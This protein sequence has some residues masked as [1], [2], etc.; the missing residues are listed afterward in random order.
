MNFSECILDQNYQCGIDLFLKSCNESSTQAYENFKCILEMID[1]K[2]ETT[3]IR[4]FL[5]NLEQHLK[6]NFSID[7]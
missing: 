6:L 2:A 3:K 7:N 1:K 4:V 5:H